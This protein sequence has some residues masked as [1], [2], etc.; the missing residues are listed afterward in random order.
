MGKV[1]P[2][3]A[4]TKQQIREALDRAIEKARNPDP[5]DQMRKDRQQKA[6]KVAKVYGF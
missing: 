6:R 3:N 4:G 2:T 1:D 5:R